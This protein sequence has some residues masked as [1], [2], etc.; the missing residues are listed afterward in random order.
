[1]VGIEMQA[2]LPSLFVLSKLDLK[3]ILDVQSSIAFTV[4]WNRITAYIS[5]G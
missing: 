1:M 5:F 3:H 4:V 2:S